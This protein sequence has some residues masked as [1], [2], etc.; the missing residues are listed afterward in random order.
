MEAVSF[1]RFAANKFQEYVQVRAEPTLP[2]EPP[3]CV[4]CTS[5]CIASS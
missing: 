5:R 4:F 1:D 3:N 2:H